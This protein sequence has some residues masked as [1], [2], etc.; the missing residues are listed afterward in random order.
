MD[1]TRL[2]ALLVLP[3]VLAGCGQRTATETSEATE[4]NGS[5]AVSTSAPAP[6]TIPDD[7]P[8]A[9]GWP[10]DSL[11]EPGPTYGLQGPS[12]ELEPLDLRACR[13]TPENTA[14]DRLTA[15]WTNVEDYRGREVTSCADPRAASTRL[16]DLADA[17]LACPEREDTSDG[18]TTVTEVTPLDA[19]AEAWQVVRRYEYDGAPAVG[20]SLVLLVRRGSGLLVDTASNEGGAGPD[21]EAQVAEQVRHQLALLDVPLEALT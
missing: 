18:Y 16:D 8:L 9:A 20:L 3:A 15:L 14:T 17:F 4:P 12:R 2:L 10:D 6:A 7:F 1:A 19:G 21:L 5:P 13:R 11:A